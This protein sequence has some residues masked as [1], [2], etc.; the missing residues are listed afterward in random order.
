MCS[1]NIKVCYEAQIEQ[2]IDTKRTP[3]SKDSRFKKAS[4]SAPIT[5][6]N[7]RTKEKREKTGKEVIP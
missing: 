2:M 4:L 7:K 3:A 1:I 6:D 5:K